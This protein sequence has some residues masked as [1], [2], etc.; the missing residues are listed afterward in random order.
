MRQYYYSDFFSG[1][2]ITKYIYFKELSHHFHQSLNMWSA[3]PQV[4]SWRFLIIMVSA[5]CEVPKVTA[6]DL[7]DN[8]N[9]TTPFRPVTMLM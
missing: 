3:R 7:V 2:I 9:A 5:I 6:I 4:R 8:F 1:K